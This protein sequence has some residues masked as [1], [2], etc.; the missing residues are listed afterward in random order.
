MSL[1]KR[2]KE[3]LKRHSL[4]KSEYSYSYTYD[5]RYD[6]TSVHTVYAHDANE[7]EVGHMEFHVSPNDKR[8]EI[9][10]SRMR[11]DPNHK[12]KGVEDGMMAHAEKSTGMKRWSNK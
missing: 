5:N 10:P 6:G 4:K 11:V 7:N 8:R 9:V 3:I 12:N 2:A 1:K